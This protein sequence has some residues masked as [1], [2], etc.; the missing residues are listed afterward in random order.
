M[1]QRTSSLLAIG[2]L[3]LALTSSTVYANNS[4]NSNLN[5]R[6]YEENQTAKKVIISGNV[7][8]TLVQDA[9]S[10]KL[11]TNDG[12][13]KARVYSTDDAIYVSSKKSGETAKITLYVGN[14]SR[15][16][17]E[18]NA[19]VNTKN[20]LN[21]QYLQIILKDNAKA[22]IS[23]KTESLYTKLV[24]ESSLKLN[25]TT[26]THAISTNELAT[27]NTKNFKA[28]KTEIENRN[29]ADYAKAK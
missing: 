28:A 22:D 8:V 25:G 11:Y 12:T 3:A 20:T 10:K 14:I 13:A 17:I 16:D 5:I 1:K 23:S 24:N 2:I 4:A 19:V 29:S 9:E 26:G 15:I 6:T 21:L 27:L 7:E 18:G